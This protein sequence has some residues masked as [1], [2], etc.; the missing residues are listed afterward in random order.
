[1]KAVIVFLIILVVAALFLLLFGKGCHCRLLDTPIADLGP[2]AIG[3][4]IL[5]SFVLLLLIVLF[6]F[7]ICL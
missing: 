3:R 2:E 6:F 1:M 7:L 4:M 5:S